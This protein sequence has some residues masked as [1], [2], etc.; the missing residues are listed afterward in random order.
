ME[1]EELFAHPNTWITNKIKPTITRKNSD[2]NLGHHIF[3]KQVFENENKIIKF[4]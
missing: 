1:L 3:L 2:Y 4:S